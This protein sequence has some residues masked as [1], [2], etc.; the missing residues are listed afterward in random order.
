M[1]ELLN[2]MPCKANIINIRE[3]LHVYK[4][5]SNNK[6]IEEQIQLITKN[7]IKYSN[8]ST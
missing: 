3:N 4:L 2:D 6:L 1:T 5:K 8:H 7:T